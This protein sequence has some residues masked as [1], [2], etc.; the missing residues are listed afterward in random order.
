MHIEELREHCISLKAVTEETPFGPDT[1]VYKI[2]GKMFAAYSINEDDLRVNLKCEPEEAIQL[3]EQHPDQIIPG[4]HMNKKHWNT[5]YVQRGLA[6]KQ[7][8]ALI[9]A[10]YNLVYNSLTKKIRSEVDEVE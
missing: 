7:I 6:D 9:K 5:V 3:R 8:I 2:G 10:S 4:Y 1:I